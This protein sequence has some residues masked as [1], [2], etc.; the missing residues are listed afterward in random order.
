MLTRSSKWIFNSMRYTG[1]N[2]SLSVIMR[3]VGIIS[4]I[5]ICRIHFCR[6]KKIEG[7]SCPHITY[8]QNITPYQFFLNRKGQLSVHYTEVPPKL[9]VLGGSA[10]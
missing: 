9:P 5:I 1:T 3:S 4:L 10:V 8:N 2:I 6:F 7:L